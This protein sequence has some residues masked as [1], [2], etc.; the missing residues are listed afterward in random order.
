M[1]NWKLK[2]PIALIIFKRPDATQKVL[3]AIRQVK[4][5]KLF[6]VADGPR[7]DQP[8]EAE[9][10]AAAR[11]V[12]DSIDWDCEVIKN[13]AD[14]NM[15]CGL[16]PATGISWVFEQVEA[17]IILEDDC[18]PDPTFF[19]FCQELLEQ[20]QDDERIMMISGTNNVMQ[21]WRYDIQD[22]HF[23]YISTAWGWAT[24]RRAWKHFDFEIKQWAQPEVRHRIADVMG[25]SK[26]CHPMFDAVYTGKQKSA[27]DI[28]WVFARLS[29]SG[30]VIT[31]ALNLVTNVGFGADA[32]HHKHANNSKFNLPARSISFPLRAP[33][34]VTVD[35]EF[36]QLRFKKWRKSGGLV[37]R[38][39][40]KL[41]KLLAH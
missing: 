25:G 5:S 36:D 1:L 29:Q 12:I 11:A 2:I 23:S 15:G 28:Q 6:V 19:R 9:K 8:D 17:A 34:T 10:C 35:R 18:V 20:Y 40:G 16:R 37:R 32:T 21:E 24:W 38:S 3:E 41:K 31:P 4:P 13:Y 7:P 30:L 14:V 26:M 39:I 33:L 22:Y 27:W